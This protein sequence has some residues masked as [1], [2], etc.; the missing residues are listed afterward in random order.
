MKIWCN[1][2]GNTEYHSYY[3]MLGCSGMRLRKK[4]EKAAQVIARA[5]GA[6]GGGGGVCGFSAGETLLLSGVGG[7][8]SG[9]SSCWSCW[10]NRCNARK[11]PIW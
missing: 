4:L 1:I 7:G 5:E 2:F 8:V 11:K 9:T 3:R 6:G 10:S